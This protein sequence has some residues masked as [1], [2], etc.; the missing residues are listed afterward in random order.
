MN[1]QTAVDILY[2]NA[3]E[4]TTLTFKPN[5]EEFQPIQVNSIQKSL[6]SILATCEALNREI[7]LIKYTL[8]NK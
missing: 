3:V 6:E 8:E 7:E 5:L 2:G 1:I 4:K